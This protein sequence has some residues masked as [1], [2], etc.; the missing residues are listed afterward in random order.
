MTVR[1]LR[2][3]IDVSQLPD[4][5]FG[6]RDIMWWGTLGFVVIEGFTLALCAASWLYLRNRTG[7][8]PPPGTPM[9]SLL[10]PSGTILSMIL[11]LPVAH[12]TAR[13]AE[14][15]R[16]RQTQVGLT[17]LSLFG[18]SFVALRVLT[19]LY[20]LNVKWDVNAYGSAQWLVTGVHGT[21]L[22]VEFV[23]VAG[24]ALIFWFGTVEDKHFS[25]VADLTF[26]WWFM[27]L[28]WIPLFFMCFLVPRWGA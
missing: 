24:M 15:Y 17:L 7:N 14:E 12:W 23:E 16:L 22:L 3:R 9:P 26:Y 8:W 11:S 5:A 25:D 28:A 4:T 1:R 18:A 27:V 10:L 2:P 6:A 13:A 21:L 20:A 19:M